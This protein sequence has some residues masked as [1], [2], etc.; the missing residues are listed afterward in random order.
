LPACHATKTPTE[1]YVDQLEAAL[2]DRSLSPRRR[3]LANMATGLGVD[4]DRIAR[5]STAATGPAWLPT[6]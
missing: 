2:L 4:R 3:A 5:A 1:A 6:P